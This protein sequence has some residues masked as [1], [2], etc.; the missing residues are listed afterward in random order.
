[1]FSLTVICGKRLKC[2][3]TIPMFSLF[4]LISSLG[5]VISSPSMTTLPLVIS[6]RRFKHLKKVDLPDPEGPIKQMTS[7][8]LISKEISFNV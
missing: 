8:S 2:W 4:L 6:S 1:M 7:P 5:S 3:N